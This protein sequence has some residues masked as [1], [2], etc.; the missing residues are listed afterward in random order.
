MDSLGAAGLHLRTVTLSIDYLQRKYKISAFTLTRLGGVKS[1]ILKEAKYL[2]VILD[3]KLS[4][5]QNTESH[6]LKA[7]YDFY[8][9]KKA[10]GK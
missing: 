8:T 5:K 2:G 7:L 4:W 10:F 6:M 9:I 1:Q 3:F